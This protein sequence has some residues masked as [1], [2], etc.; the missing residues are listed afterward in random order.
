MLVDEAYYEFHGVTALPLLKRFPN[1][2]VCRTFSKAFGMAGL[3]LGCL[4]S[5]PENQRCK[6]CT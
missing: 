2:F 3:R 1:L 6:E 4:I 5:D